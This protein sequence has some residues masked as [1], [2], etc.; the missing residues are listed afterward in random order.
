MEMSIQVQGEKSEGRPINPE[1]GK[2]NKDERQKSISL[3]SPFYPLKQCVTPSCNPVFVCRKTPLPHLTK[4]KSAKYVLSPKMR[5]ISFVPQMVRS[6][7]VEFDPWLKG[8][9]DANIW[10]LRIK[11]DVNRT[12]TSSRSRRAQKKVESERPQHAD[13][14]R[15]QNFHLI[16]DAPFSRLPEPDPE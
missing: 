14:L 8:S 15:G 13:H 9:N 4:H 3:I 1:H 12:L 11:V 2:K 6:N 10:G 7:P 16:A 5:F